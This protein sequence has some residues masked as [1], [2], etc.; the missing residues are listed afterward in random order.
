[1]AKPSDDSVFIIIYKESSKIYCVAK[2]ETAAKELIINKSELY[3]QHWV[4]F[5]ESGSDA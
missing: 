5:E 4:L 2:T 1:M 3:Y